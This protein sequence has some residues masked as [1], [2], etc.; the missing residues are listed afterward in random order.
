M[1]KSFERTTAN[2]LTKISTEQLRLIVEKTNEIILVLQ[3]NLMVYCNQK[4]VELAGYS[5]EKLKNTPFV[6]FIHPDDRPLVMERYKKRLLEEDVP[7]IYSFRLIKKN[8]EIIWIQVNAVAIQ[9]NGQPASLSFA[10]NISFQRLTQQALQESEEKYKNIVEIAHDAIVIHSEGKVVFTNP[11]AIRLLGMNSTADL[12]GRPVIDFVH[13]DYRDFAIQRIQKLL[14]GEKIQPRA[15]EVFVRSDGMPVF[16]EVSGIP[17]TF[18]GKPAIQLIIRDIGERKKQ[19]EALEASERKYRELFENLRDGWVSTDMDGHFIECN[20][21]FLDMLGY[22]MAE[23]KEKRYADLTPQKWHQYE[24]KI[25][26][27]Q[28][29]KRGYSGIYE[30]EYIRKDGTVFPV[31]LSIYLQTNPSGKPMG[32]WG[33]IRNISDRKTAQDAIAISEHLYRLTLANISDAVFVTDNSGN[34]TF[35]CPSTEIIFGYTKDEVVSMGN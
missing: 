17:T 8:G 11:A 22:S 6:E 14:K 9:W 30:K 7:N 29:I 31:E 12:I 3:N 34:F 2:S 4:V 32:M 21:A 16:V 23:I 33:L 15:E 1:N 18:N 13:P 28:I 25:V 35:V 24:Q 19:I 27:E 5:E 10:T 26:R 20:Q